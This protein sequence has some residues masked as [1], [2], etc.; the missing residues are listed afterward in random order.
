[1]STTA[2]ATAAPAAPTPHD[3]ADQILTRKAPSYTFTFSPFL[4]ST[5]RF[6][7]APTQ[8]AC[9]PYIAGHC[10]LGASCPDRHP[11]SPSSSGHSNYNNLVCKHWLRGLCKKGDHCEFLHEYNLRRMP[12]C[13]FFTR[14]AYCSN[15][16]ECLYLHIDPASRLPP[17]ASYDRG[18]C[19]LGPRCAARHAPR[20]LCPFYLAGFCPAGRACKDGAHARWRADKD[21]EPPRVRVDRD[22]EE[23]AAEIARRRE[24]AEREEES[25]RERFGGGRGG[26]GGRWVGRG[27]GFGGG[28]VRRQRGRGHLH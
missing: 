3:L 20:V 28:D 6:G 25:Q 17:C 13:S 4:L 22:P 27:G 18:F 12:E 26:R 8:P 16:D 21:L 2:T 23:V 10:P 19:P 15:G 1:M 5:Y 24:D 9:K 14:N 11:A 7:V